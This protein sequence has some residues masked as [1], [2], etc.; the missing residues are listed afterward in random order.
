MHSESALEKKPGPGLAKAVGCVLT[1]GVAV[2][3]RAWGGGAWGQRGSWRTYGK[4]QQAG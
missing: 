2:A 1:G 3:A 4:R